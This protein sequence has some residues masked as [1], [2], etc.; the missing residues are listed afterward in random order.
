MIGFG[1]RGSQL[2]R[3]VYAEPNAEVVGV[4]DLYDGHLAR[5]LELAEDRS[6]PATTKRYQEIL[7]RQDIDA[8]VIAVPD[9]WHKRVCLDALAAGKHVYCEKPLLHK[10]E[11]GPTSSPPSS[12]QERSSKWAAST[13]VHRM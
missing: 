2:V 9:F 1:I 4:S 3:N 5:A 7:A 8:V 12:D 6:K 11:D 13:S 10:I